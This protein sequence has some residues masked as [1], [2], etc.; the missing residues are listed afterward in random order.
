MEFYDE[1]AVRQSYAC[2]LGIG[3]LDVV[4]LLGYMIADNTVGP[5]VL[6]TVAGANAN[7]GRKHSK[8]RMRGGVRV[9]RKN[10]S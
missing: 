10:S 6:D 4:T 5:N 1:R 7:Q 9:R 2:L 8:E 3:L